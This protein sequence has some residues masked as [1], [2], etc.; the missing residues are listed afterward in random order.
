MTSTRKECAC[1]FCQSVSSRVHSHYNRSFQDLPIQ[2]KKVVITLSNRKM[3]CDN[4]S[5]HRTT[6]AETFSFI[7]NKAKKTKRLKETILEVSL[8][9]SSVS[10]AVYLSKHVVDVKKSTICNYQKKSILV[11]NKEDIEAICIDDFAMKKRKSYGTI[12]VNLT[13]GRVIDL[14][15]SR[16]KDDVVIWLFLFP[17]IKYF[18]RDGSLTYASA[19]REA[20]PD[21]HHISDRFHLVKNLTDAST[22]CMYRILAGRIVIPLTK[23]KNAMNELL[24]SKLS[25]RTKVLWVKSLASQGLTKQDIRTQTKCS[26]QTIQKYSRMREEEIPKDSEDQRGREH[27]EAIQRIMDKV[28]EVKALQEKGYSSRKIS[29]ETGYTKRTIKNYLSHNFNPIHGQYGVQRPG[30][31]SAF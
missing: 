17:N 27:N 13:D 1:P 26:L 11:I 2:D 29:D 31:L 15:E 19:I 23:E 12:M 28:K 18:S 9:Q 20:H 8:T 25:R 21:A 30:K 7:D 4:P 22:L 6:F 5:C 16:E 3:F 10:A 24:T 14:I